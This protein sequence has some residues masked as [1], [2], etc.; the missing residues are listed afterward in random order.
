MIEV[1]LLESTFSSLQ[2]Q[3]LMKGTLDH[4]NPSHFSSPSSLF[5][6]YSC[7]VAQ[8]LCVSSFFHFL[9]IPAFNLDTQ[10]KD[11]KAVK[12]IPWILEM[13]S[14]GATEWMHGSEMDMRYKIVS[15][16]WSEIYWNRSPRITG[17]RK[18]RTVILIPKTTP[19]LS[20][21]LRSLVHW[22]LQRSI[23]EAGFVFLFFHKENERNHNRQT[24]REDI[25]NDQ[26][27]SVLANPVYEEWVRCSI[28]SYIHIPYTSPPL[29][30]S[31]TRVLLASSTR[32]YF[33]RSSC[34]LE[35]QSHRSV[36][37]RDC[38]DK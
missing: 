36:K 31:P 23:D 4:K 11:R 19:L 37:N 24:W 38:L 17:G 10:E 28:E 32:L 3:A 29:I 13:L 12:D 6:R 33:F 35:Q 25:T 18:E 9:S 1:S 15:S 26:T 21:F 22:F 16:S 7:N 2:T 27:K 14:L 34:H 30:I 8:Q 5:L 20:A